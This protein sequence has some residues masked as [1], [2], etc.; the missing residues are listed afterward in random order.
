[1]GPSMKCELA[2]ELTIATA[3]EV[4][5]KLLRALEENPS[6]DVDTHDVNEVD[7]A[8]IQ[9]L[10]V[11]LS[12]ASTKGI[13]VH[14]PAEQHGAVVHEALRSMGLDEHDWQPKAAKA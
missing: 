12:S 2:G 7:T 3:S 11:A 1:M 6:L 8:G 14:F 4:K 13:D 5:A 10:V 9:L